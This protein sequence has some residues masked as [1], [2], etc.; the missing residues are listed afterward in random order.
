VDA[1]LSKKIAVL[2][3]AA[4]AC[5]VVFHAYPGADGGSTE[6]FLSLA[7]ARW[8]LPFLGVLSGYLFF[9]TFKPTAAGYVAKLRSRTRTILIPFLIWSGLTVLFALATADPEFG[10]PIDSLGEAFSHWLLRPVATPLWF[11][12]ALMGCVVLSPLVYLVVRTLRGWVLPLAAAWWV[13]GVQPEALWPWISAVALPPFIAGAAIAL[14]RPDM[15]WARRAAPLPLAAALTAAWLGAAA[16]FTLY[17][18]D[19]GPWMRAAMLPVVVLGAFAMWTGLDALGRPLSAVPRLATASLAVAPLAFFVYV[20][21][22]PQLKAVMLL[23]DDHGAD[24][25]GLASYLLAPAITMAFSLSA[26]LLLRRLAPGALALASGGRIVSGPR[27]G[28]P[29]ATP[30]RCAVS[31]ARVH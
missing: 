26:G 19:L 1:H 22:Q 20:T 24:L 15:A 14:L 21:Q 7:L 12:Q 28:P 27:G 17:G 30:E 23:L 6:A 4:V 13:T 31:P 11:L 5:V 2:R 3:L 9:R 25:P 29:Q 8:A 16:L 10:G 18:L